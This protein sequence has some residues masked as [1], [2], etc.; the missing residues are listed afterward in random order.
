MLVEEGDQDL[1]GEVLQYNRKQ[2]AR[3]ARSLPRSKLALNNNLARDSNLSRVETDLVNC[4]LI[5][6]LFVYE[7]A[8]RYDILFVAHVSLALDT[9]NIFS[10][11]KLF[12]G[13][14]L[15]EV[16]HDWLAH[17]RG[18]MNDDSKLI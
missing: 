17:K 18:V 8:T 13:N 10:D 11:T 14:F 4:E 7:H 12:I 1:A 15:M 6:L 5:W 16:K 2:V 9:G 3:G